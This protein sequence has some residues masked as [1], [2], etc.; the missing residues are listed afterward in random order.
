M[1]D[2]ENLRHFHAVGRAGTLSGA[3]RALKVD[4]ATVSRRLAALEAELEVVL[5]ERLP[6]SCR[7]TPIGRQIF[8]QAEAM[9]ES[10]FGIERVARATR[11][12]LA[13]DVSLS[14]PPSLAVFLLAARVAAF[15]A[16]TPHV[17]LSVL[18][19]TQQ[20]SLSRREA[21]LALRIVRPQEPTCVIRKVG[22]MPFALYSSHDYGARHRPDDWAFIGYSAEMADMPQPQWLHRVAAGR[23][24]SCLLSDISSHVAAARHGAGVVGLP[25]FIGDAEPGLVRLPPPPV[26]FVPDLW[27]AVHRDLRHSAPVR[28]VIDFVVDAIAKHESLR[29]T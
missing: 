20:V 18:A 7:L 25:C 10:A 23:A 11:Q 6:R 27:L 16:A 13:G 28:T 2:W 24:I 19:Q 8:E 21:D 9:D 12:S 15:H 29:L 5:V 1:L 26:P 4:H 3:A 22:R 14:A 17:R